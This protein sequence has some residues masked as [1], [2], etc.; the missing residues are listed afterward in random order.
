MGTLVQ[1]YLAWQKQGKKEKNRENEE[2]VTLYSRNSQEKKTDVDNNY[3]TF[4][5][6]FFRNTDDYKTFQEGERIER[7]QCWMKICKCSSIW[8]QNRWLL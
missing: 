4:P 3:K 5:C 2:K 8:R 1:I 7:K 6:Y